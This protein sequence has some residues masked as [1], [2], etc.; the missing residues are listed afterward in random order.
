LFVVKES[1]SRDLLLA[2]H[3]KF[4]NRRHHGVIVRL[5]IFGHPY[6]VKFF[7]KAVSAV[8]DDL[9]LYYSIIEQFAPAIF[10]Y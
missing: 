8:M 4:A 7:R 10:P 3:R 6:R 9:E 5:G 2:H 1:A